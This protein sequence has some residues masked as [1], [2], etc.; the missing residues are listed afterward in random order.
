MK[1]LTLLLLMTLNGTALAAT[2]IDTPCPEATSS[3]DVL[4]AFIEQDPG[5]VVQTAS[6]TLATPVMAEEPARKQEDSEA[7]DD[8]EDE[9][10]PQPEFTTS[11][12]GVAVNDLPGFRRHMYRTDI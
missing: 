11:L 12:P 9:E 8:A 2:D 7:V 5:T 6:D 3:S 4:H 1:T 10:S